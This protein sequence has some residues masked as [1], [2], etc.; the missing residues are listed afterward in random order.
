MI[1]IKM[2]YLLEVMLEVYGC[3]KVIVNVNGFDIFSLKRNFLLLG[4]EIECIKG[5]Y[6]M[7]S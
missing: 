6:Y 7:V 2:V 4:F 3:L 1:I 5:K